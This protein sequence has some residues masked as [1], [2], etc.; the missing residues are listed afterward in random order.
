MG[1]DYY[2]INYEVISMEIVD[3]NT[4]VWRNVMNVDDIKYFANL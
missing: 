2:R 3:Y 1:S 4:D